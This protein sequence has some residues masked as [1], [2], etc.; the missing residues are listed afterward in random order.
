MDQKIKM[1]IET[2]DCP[3]HGKMKGAV[4]FRYNEDGKTVADTI[5]CARC[6]CDALAELV[7]NKMNEGTFREP[8]PDQQPKE[9]DDD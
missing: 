2:V 4:H 5:V 3:R 7:T 8:I 6:Y 9:T 1:E